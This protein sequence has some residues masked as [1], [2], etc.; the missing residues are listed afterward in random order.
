M[1][2]TRALI[3]VALLASGIGVQ[4]HQDH[5]AGAGAKRCLLLRVTVV[6]TRG[7]DV[8]RGSPGDDVIAGL[9]GD[10]RIVGL[11]GS[12]TL[13]GGPGDDVLRGGSGI[14]FVAPGGGSDRANGGRNRINVLTYLR[15][16]SPV[17]VD[18][19]GHS[20]RGWG[21]D[22]VAGFHQVEGSFFDDV[23]RGA[24]GGNALIGFGGRDR[25]VGRG[26]DDSL[27]GGTGADQ[28]LAGRGSDYVAFIDSPAPVEVDLAAGTASGEGK[29]DIRGVEN[30]FGSPGDDVLIGNAKGNEF[31][32]GVSGDDRFVGRAGNDAFW[33]DAG[34]GDLDG[35]SGRD[36]VFYAFSGTVDLTSG[37][38]VGVDFSDF[39]VA[40]E[41]AA[42][43]GG[44]HTL[45][46]DEN[47]NRLEGGSSRDVLEG[48]GGDDDIHGG[49]GADALAGG[50]GID[51]LN[52]GA[53]EDACLEGESVSACEYGVVTT[54][55]DRARRSRGTARGC[56]ILRRL[57][58]S[59]VC[60]IPGP[61]TVP[62]QTSAPRVGEPSR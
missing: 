19:R 47:D 6:G 36:R 48:R 33:R 35:G 58:S 59:I 17:R 21:R 52:G 50:D 10:D 57:S 16:P 4:Q 11:A 30:L 1:Q 5:A 49:R 62:P 13:C 14:D 31:I 23:I 46:G 54:T 37:T 24:A 22:T 2:V 38:A 12:D 56:S 40:I 32:G 34:R 15:S 27:I 43:G 39:L 20:A 18:L 25:L 45:I 44:R 42:G 3:A 60:R 51:V 29:D 41:D 55:L 7:D 61:L 8:L 53:G 26:G 9:A 28:L